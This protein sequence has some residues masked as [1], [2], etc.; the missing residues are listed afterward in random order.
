MGFMSYS[1]DFYAKELNELE[2]SVITEKKIYRAKQL[3]KMLDDLVDEGY[4]ELYDALE[5]T[6]NGVSR[7]K[8]YIIDN[9]AEPFALSSKGISTGTTTYGTEIIELSKAI[10]DVYKCE[11]PTPMVS[12]DAFIQKLQ[13]FCEWVGYEADTAYIYFF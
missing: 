1:L 9:N 3:L 7:L 12:N 6:Y 2:N 8:Q 5:D 11:L 10:N 13:A 4:T